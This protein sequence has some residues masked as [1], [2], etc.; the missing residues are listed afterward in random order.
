MIRC[1]SLRFYQFYLT[2]VYRVYNDCLKHISADSAHLTVTKFGP[3]SL[4][5]RQNSTFPSDSN[6]HVTRKHWPK[7]KHW[8]VGL[9]TFQTLA[10]PSGKFVTVCY[11]KWPSRNSWFSQLNSMVNL[12]IVFCGTLPGRISP[13]ELVVVNS[14]SPGGDGWCYLYELR[15]RGQHPWFNVGK[16]SG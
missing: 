1:W 3:E 16:R 15:A 14:S 6:G 13:W 7:L 8:L 9:G 10:I 4:D 2:I 11:W 5:H 12:S